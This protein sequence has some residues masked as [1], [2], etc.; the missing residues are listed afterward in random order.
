VPVAT[1]GRGYRCQ[2]LQV[3]RLRGLDCEGTVELLA[4]KQQKGWLIARL[5][6]CNLP[7]SS[8]RRVVEVWVRSH[9]LQP[10]LLPR[11]TSGDRLPAAMSPSIW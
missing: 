6:A 9:T 7:R 5:Y 2:R 3:R 1:G 8:R 11:R 4:G 10:V